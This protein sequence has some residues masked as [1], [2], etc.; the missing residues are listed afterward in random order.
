[1]FPLDVIKTRKQVGAS[2][3]SDL[4]HGLF[5]SLLAATTQNFVYFY[6][7]SYFR[8]SYSSFFNLSSL[9]T[10]TELLIG[11][12]SGASSQVFTLPL[13][14]ITTRQQTCTPQDRES[15]IK[16]LLS[17]VNQ[18]GVQGLWRGLEASLIL[19]VNPAITYGLFEKIKATLIIDSSR[20]LSTFEAFFIGV[21]S[22]TLA[23]IVTYPYIMAKVRIQHKPTDNSPFEV[24]KE[25]VRKQ[26]VG[27]LFK[28]MR[29]QIIKAVLSQAILFAVK[30]QC[31]GWVGFLARVLANR[32]KRMKA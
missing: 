14:V 21:V 6:S 17:I 11:G 26:G 18:D 1:M 19:C 24:I 22:K 32:N 31:D 9:N 20:H 27:G 7:H 28:G 13:S 4:Y 10:P 16:T 23:T 8:S 3:T 12:I 30:E 5:A 2:H 29:L 25:V 15:F